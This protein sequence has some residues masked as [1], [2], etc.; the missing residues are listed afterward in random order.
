MDEQIV[1]F[2]KGDGHV[3]DISYFDDPVAAGGQRAIRIPRGVSTTPR[4]GTEKNSANERPLD[5]V[6]MNL[7]KVEM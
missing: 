3:P 2:R 7:D 4:A 6:K 1:I 5:L